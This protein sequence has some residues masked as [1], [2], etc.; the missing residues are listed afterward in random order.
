MLPA[1]LAAFAARSATKTGIYAF[2]R[3]AEPELPAAFTKK[4]R[5]EKSAWKFFQAQPPGYRRLWLHH[6]V[7]AKQ[8]ATR[9]R[10]LGQLI[11]ASIQAK[12][13]R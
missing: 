11:T 2:D 5:L 6:V 3:T 8:P 4:F 10:R 1:G 9:Q 13:L 7:S 12:R